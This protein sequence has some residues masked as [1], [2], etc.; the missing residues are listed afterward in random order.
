MLT[1]TNDFGKQHFRADALGKKVITLTIPSQS[2]VQD[3]CKHL[4][5]ML[6][7]HVT[8]FEV[9][10]NMISG[11]GTEHMA[12]MSSLLKMGVGIRLVS[13]NNGSILEL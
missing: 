12:I 13:Y 4:G 6:K 8:D 3:L 1:F 11:S 2:S 5:E 7:T 9:G 10:L